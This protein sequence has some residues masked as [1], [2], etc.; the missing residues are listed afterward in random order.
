MNT[1]S[2]EQLLFFQIFGHNSIEN[3]ILFW[4]QGSFS[5]YVKVSI[6]EVNVITFMYLTIAAGSTCNLAYLRVA[7]RVLLLSNL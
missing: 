7:G 2:S 6:Y 3:L 4:L 1:F 5:F